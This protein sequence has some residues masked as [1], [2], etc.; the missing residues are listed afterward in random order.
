MEPNQMPCR[1]IRPDDFQIIEQIP[2]IVGVARD[3]DMRMFWCTTCF[4]SRRCR[5]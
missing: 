1:P 5:S 3:E 4:F 2:G